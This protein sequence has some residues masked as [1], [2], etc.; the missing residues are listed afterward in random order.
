MS[1]LHVPE[2]GKQYV[3]KDDFFPKLKT[4][5]SSQLVILSENVGLSLLDKVWKY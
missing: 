1:Q 4:L 2:A 5:Q 3:S